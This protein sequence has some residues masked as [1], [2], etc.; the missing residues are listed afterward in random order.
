MTLNATE[1]RQAMLAGAGAIALWGALA[2][3]S[4]L[5]GPVPPFQMVAMTF[6]VGATIGIMRARIRGLPLSALLHWPARVWLLG[7]GG[8]FGYHALYFAALQLAP[9]AEANLVN[10]LWPLLIVLLST[11]LAGERLGWPHLVGAALGF[12]GV[13]LLAVSR[14]VGFASGYA[15]GYALAL[16]CA[17][18]WSLYS[19]LSRRFGETPTDAIAA[20]CAAA[21]V[22]SLV[23]H[24]LF[25]HT[26]WPATPAAWLAVLALGLGPTGGAFYLWDHAVKRGDI[27][28]LG[29]LSYAAPILSTA[30]LIACGLATPTSALLLAALLVTAGAV[31]AS[32]DL[33]GR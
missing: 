2:T 3:L 6:T 14:G 30:L 19:V 26:V 32:R 4:V 20:F 27:R 21:A 15:L 7:I 16:G 25:E 11:P 33:W 5:A 9:P 23:C 18:T 28:A 29:A 31:L 17:F 12:A 8:L 13:A 1:R 10:Y 24:L 22:L